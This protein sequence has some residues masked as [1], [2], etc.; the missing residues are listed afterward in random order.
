VKRFRFC[1]PFYSFIYIHSL[2]CCNS[3]LPL[4][5]AFSSTLFTF[6]PSALAHV[7]ALHETGPPPSC[8]PSLTPLP[9]KSLLSILS[10]LGSL[11]V[12]TPFAFASLQQ[13]SSTISLS[14]SLANSTCI[15]P[16][17]QSSK[18]VGRVP[19]ADL[20]STNPSILIEQEPKTDSCHHNRKNLF[21][22]ISSR[23]DS[24][25]RAPTWAG[26]VRMRLPFTEINSSTSLLLPVDHFTG[27]DQSEPPW[28]INSFWLESRASCS[29]S[30]CPLSADILQRP[31]ILICR[32]HRPQLIRL[33]H[34]HARTATLRKRHPK[35]LK[36]L[37]IL[38]R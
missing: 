6:A 20:L 36:P 28:K 35:P 18:G 9:R 13:E 17:L 11:T 22:F 23:L 14:A 29:L 1:R 30:T 16:L 7:C 31:P 24:Q 10:Y 32:S 12:R 4:G 37:S 21:L 19:I 33:S 8:L 15:T 5:L 2:A 27:G 34:H 3:F 25:V 38:N 26:V